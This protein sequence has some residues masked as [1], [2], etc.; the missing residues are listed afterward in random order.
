MVHKPLSDHL[1]AL[2]SAANRAGVHDCATTL[3]LATG[4]STGS[5]PAVSGLRTSPAEKYSAIAPKAIYPHLGAERP[6]EI[7]LGDHIGSGGMADVDSAIQMS[8]SREVVIKRVKSGLKTEA[9]YDALC[10]EAFIMGQLEHP[11]IPPVHEI[12]YIE[13]APLVI[14]KRIFGASW[15]CPGQSGSRES[16]LEDLQILIQ[17]SRAIEYAQSKG[18]IHRDIKPANVMIGGFGEVYLL[19]WGCAVEL[20]GSGNFY[21]TGFQG[22]PRYAA[23]EMVEGSEPLTHQT[24]VYLL[25]ATLHHILT[26]HGP[27]MGESFVDT[28]IA[29]V[30]SPEYEYDKEIDTELAAIANR[31]TSRQPAGRFETATGFREA[32]EEYVRYFHLHD[33]LSSA[34]QSSQALKSA[35]E[36]VEGDF[37]SFYQHAFAGRFACQQVLEIRPKNEE[38]HR[39]N[40]EILLLLATHEIRLMHLNIARELIKQIH[41]LP[42]DEAELRKLEQ[43]YNKQESKHQR[44]DELST[45]IQYKLLE[46]LQNP[47][48]QN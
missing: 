38:A 29:A 12:A 36:A 40:T 6:F 5:S 14:M 34:E 44:A 23:P 15:E 39:T 28:V 42:H 47:D 48:V 19:D 1:A 26:G 17:I 41:S 13:D 32:I 24:D 37:F 18:I 3:T 9:N 2:E 21:S 16:L 45:Q 10:R 43:L 30:E 20:D 35:L 4:P 22:T 25:G 46:K 27:H 7:I 31:A 33:L 11:N 8:L